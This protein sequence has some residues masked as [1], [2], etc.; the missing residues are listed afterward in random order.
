MNL[1]LF[2]ERCQKAVQSALD[3]AQSYSHQHVTSL[4]LLHVVCEN[5]SAE[6]LKLI[7]SSR[8]GVRDIKS[9][10]TKEL[11]KRPKVQGSADIFLDVGLKKVMEIAQNQAKLNGDS[12]VT[13][14]VL[15]LSLL[16]NSE[17]ADCLKLLG[18]S[19]KEV[20]LAAKQLRK[21]K[22]VNSPS[23]ED[24]FEALERYT[25]D[26]CRLALE[27]KIDPI[28]GRDEEIRRSMQV[29]SRR[30]KNNP[31][32]IG[33]PGVGKTAIAEG[34]SLRI[35]NR[36]VPE[37]LQD[38]RLLALDMGALIAGAKFRGEF[39]ERL[40]AILYEVE[41]SAGEIILFIDE[42]HTLVGAGKTDGALMRLTY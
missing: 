21:G 22:K 10:L 24:N 36:D 42:M 28:I 1:E 31:V 27:G 9:T 12:H 19:F 13:I 6:I 26:F 15:F 34:L 32:L 20:V 41:T 11:E 29:L 37:P 7:E 23:A 2:S 30:T 8:V 17:I 40:K 14:D 33:H 38:K 18:F 5:P 25:R 3:L 16:E 4:H 35:V 39:E